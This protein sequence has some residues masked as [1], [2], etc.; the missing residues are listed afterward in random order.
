MTKKVDPRE[1][2]QAELEAHLD[3][4]VASGLEDTPE[5]ADAYAVWEG[6]G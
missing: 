1:L 4:L 5:F 2:S 6:R 3:V